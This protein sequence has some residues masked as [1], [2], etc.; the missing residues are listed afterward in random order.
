M[1]NIL[2]IHGYVQTGDTVRYNTG[3]LQTELCHI[4]VLHYVDGPRMQD[5]SWGDS[6]P[7]W[8]LKNGSHWLDPDHKNSRWD[9]TAQVWLEH[10][11]KHQ[12]DGVNGLSQGSALTPKQQQPIQFAILC[13]SQQHSHKKIYDVPLDLP[14]VHS[15][16]VISVDGI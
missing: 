15:D 2:V 10:L 6:R 5:P 1:L 7:W 14:T 11:S 9:E 16:R 4:A 12:Y 3:R 13:P 8:I